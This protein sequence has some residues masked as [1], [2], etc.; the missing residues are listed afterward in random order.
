MKS[1][2]CI[3]CSN[4]LILTSLFLLTTSFSFKAPTIDM[5]NINVGTFINYTGISTAFPKDF[6]FNAQCGIESYEVI[7]QARR[8]DPI[9]AVNKGAKFN[10]S[11][12]KLIRYAKPGDSYIFYKI[13]SHCVG[14]L[15]SR[16]LPSL[17][18]QIK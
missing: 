5:H 13:K 2:I 1:I 7:Y 4:L 8:K 15:V 18:I 10:S 11:V 16:K 9:V 6:N 17:I 3:A 12:Q 14:D